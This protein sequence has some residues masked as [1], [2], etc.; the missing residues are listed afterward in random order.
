MNTDDPLEDTSDLSRAYPQLAP[1]TLR[2]LTE[3]SDFEDHL[4]AAEWLIRHPRIATIGYTL[5]YIALLVWHPDQEFI[6][7][8]L[9]EHGNNITTEVL[10]QTIGVSHLTRSQKRCLRLIAPHTA[11]HQYCELAATMM[12]RWEQILPKMKAMK[13]QSDFYMVEYFN[14]IDNFP[15]LLA[16][17]WFRPDTVDTYSS[18]LCMAM[19]YLALKGL[20]EAV[21]ADVLKNRMRKREFIDTL[22]DKADRYFSRDKT[23]IPFLDD[24]QTLAPHPVI[25]LMDRITG[26]TRVGELR[27]LANKLDL[28]AG[29]ID[30]LKAAIEGRGYYYHYRFPHKVGNEIALSEE[31]LLELRGERLRKLLTEKPQITVCDLKKYHVI[32]QFKGKGNCS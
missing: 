16:C 22:I 19:V 21:M 18:G 29:S 32:G 4:F 6:G 12:K 28:C 15:F 9:R 20:P 31:G 23:V 26:I 25:P 30:Y 3:L 10:S 17:H 14:L 11:P 1:H 27:K 24:E 13:V 2:E 8:L 5:S 7:K